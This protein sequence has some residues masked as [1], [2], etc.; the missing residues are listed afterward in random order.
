VLVRHS[1]LK[2]LLVGLKRL[3]VGARSRFEKLPVREDRIE[4][5]C[6][7][8]SEKGWRLSLTS[9]GCARCQ[10]FGLVGQPP[11]LGDR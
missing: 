6:A 3:L 4:M 8:L 11:A 9:L 1:L 5:S 2:R 7:C 10:F